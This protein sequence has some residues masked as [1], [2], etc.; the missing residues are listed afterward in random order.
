MKLL[1]F[2]IFIFGSISLYGQEFT[3][4]TEKAYQDSIAKLN[5]ANAAKGLAESNYNMGITFFDAKKYPQAIEKFAS[6]IA[7]DPTFTAPYFNKAVAEIATENYSAAS[8]SLSALLA[9]DPAFEKAYF[10]R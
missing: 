4:D 1:I 9:I 10:H 6:A 8:N 2:A 5:E 3:S 7:A